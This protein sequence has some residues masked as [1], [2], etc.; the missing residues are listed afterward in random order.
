MATIRSKQRLRIAC[1]SSM[2]AWPLRALRSD[3]AVKPAM[4]AT[5]K[6]PRSPPVRSGASA[7][8]PAARR[9]ANCGT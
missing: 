3:S 2:P 6:A 8:A 5:N 1:I 7:L 4:S 9:R